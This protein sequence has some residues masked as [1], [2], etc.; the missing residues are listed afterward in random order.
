MIYINIIYFFYNAYK[1]SYFYFILL[2]VD[3]IIILKF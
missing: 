1:L 2:I 3:F